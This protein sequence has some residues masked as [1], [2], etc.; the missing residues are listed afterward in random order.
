MSEMCFY[1]GFNQDW[2]HTF[3]CVNGNCAGWYP[4]DGKGDKDKGPWGGMII[5]DGAY[6]KDNEKVPKSHCTPIP[7]C[8][9]KA[10]HQCM[11]QCRLNPPSSYSLTDSNCFTAAKDC[12]TQC[13]I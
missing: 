10:M 5:S 12:A 7:N 9:E 2:P 8:D 13:A 4:T 11:L 6:F 3:T 1:P